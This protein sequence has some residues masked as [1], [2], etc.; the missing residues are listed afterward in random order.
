VHHNILEESC[1]ISKT[2]QAN[3]ICQDI[4]MKDSEIEVPKKR[5]RPFEKDGIRLNLRINNPKWISLAL[6]PRGEAAYFSV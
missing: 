5:G 1:S 2:A 3:S 4:D 6:L